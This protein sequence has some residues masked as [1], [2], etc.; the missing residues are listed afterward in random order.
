MEASSNVVLDFSP[1]SQSTGSY[2]SVSFSG[3]GTSDSEIEYTWQVSTDGGTTY[4]DIENTGGGE[5]TQSE[6][7]ISGGAMPFGN[8][9][10]NFIEIYANA[11][12][13]SDEYYIEIQNQGNEIQ[14]FKIPDLKEEQYLIVY[15]NNSNFSN[16]FGYSWYGSN[17]KTRTWNNLDAYKFDVS[18]SIKRYSD[19]S[20]VDAYGVAGQSGTYPWTAFKGFF[21][22]KPNKFA[23]STYNPSDWELCRDCL[24]G[25]TNANSS[26]PY[27]GGVSL[28]SAS[29]YTGLNTATLSVNSPPA[30]FDGYLYKLKMKT[31]NRICD[32]GVE[33]TLRHFL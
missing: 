28:D 13:N 19:N 12:V 14:T 7:M 5:G 17:Y 21:K 20:V 6:I 22:R 30:Y 1:I 4:T 8:R 26:T 29:L 24:D 11:K 3:T 15:D 9:N 16:A 23:Q 2:G 10:Y 27:V 32:P 33:T 31:K 18:I 25:S